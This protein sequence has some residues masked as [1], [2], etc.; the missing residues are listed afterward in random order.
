MRRRSLNPYRITV[1][2]EAGVNFYA[3]AQEYNSRCIP[4]YKL[5]TTSAQTHII[6]G[7]KT[8]KRT[9][10]ADQCHVDHPGR[11]AYSHPEPGV[12]Y[13]CYLSEGRVQCCWAAA[14][15]WRLRDA[16]ACPLLAYIHFSTAR[17][18]VTAR[19]SFCCVYKKSGWRRRLAW[20]GW[21]RSRA[22]LPKCWAA[23]PP[24]SQAGPPGQ[25]TGRRK[26][27]PNKSK[28]KIAVPCKHK[29]GGRSHGI[30]IYFVE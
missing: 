21:P 6:P 8:Y 5:S 16:A 11:R 9:V 13:W 15:P 14:L 28:T 10:L 12:C 18:G 20:P 3:G 26:A 30:F 24:R 17:D 29:G 4:H 2:R 19:L 27:K 22:G 25:A 23:V 7:Y 1:R